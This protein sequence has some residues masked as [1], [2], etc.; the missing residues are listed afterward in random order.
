MVQVGLLVLSLLMFGHAYAAAT[1]DARAD[2]NHGGFAYAVVSDA[3]AELL[4]VFGTVIL[5]CERVRDEFEANNRELERA[6]M[7]LETVA[8]TDGL[9]G[10][11]NRRAFEEW[12]RLHAAD[13]PSGCVAAID[14]ND[15]KQLNDSHLHA[16]GD[17][18]LKL[19][20]RALMNR[21][22]VTDPIFRIGGDE[23]AIFMPGGHADELARRMDAIDRDLENLRLPGVPLP[24][25]LRI[26]WGVADYS[27]EFGL[28]QAIQ[29][30]D[31]E[32]YAQKARRK[33]RLPAAHDSHGL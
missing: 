24:Y 30:A 10:L 11:L 3:L 19:V 14:L 21:F 25:T 13:S 20:G 2:W 31:R 17:A 15:L 28:E 16:A 7:E 32:M 29:F 9:T 33:V 26:A 18:A 6:K 4:I 27:P 1:T 23:F 12:P 5:A 8:R 22:R